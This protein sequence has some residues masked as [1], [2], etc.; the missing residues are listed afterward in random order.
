MAWERGPRI[1]VLSGFFKESG[2]ATVKEIGA[3]ASGIGATE[4]QV[5][6]PRTEISNPVLGPDV[7]SRQSSFTRDQAAPQEKVVHKLFT[8]SQA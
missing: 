5:L 4:W 2:E 7:L 6:T 3:P 8:K 1:W